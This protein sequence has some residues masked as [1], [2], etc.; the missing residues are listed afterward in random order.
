MHFDAPDLMAV[1]AGDSKVK[2]GAND[3]YNKIKD[4]NGT[5]KLAVGFTSS[6]WISHIQSKV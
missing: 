6:D 4:T 1:M 3:A 2:A 5:T